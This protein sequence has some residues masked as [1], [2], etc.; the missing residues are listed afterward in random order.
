MPPLLT[1]GIPN[2]NRSAM[3]SD[4]IRRIISL[5]PPDMTQ[6]IE[7]FVSDNN[8]SEDT[9]TVV[10]QILAE[11]RQIQLRFTRNKQNVGFSRNFDKTIKG[12]NGKFVFLMSNDD[13]L[14]DN[15]LE[16]VLNVIKKHPDIGLGFFACQ[17]YDSHLT[18]AVDSFA[19]GLD[20]YYP[21][22]ID[23]V[24]ESGSCAPCLISGWLVN[25]DMW[26]CESREEWMS[27]NAAQI[28]IGMSLLAKHPCY[29][30]R[31]SPVV[32][33]RAE[34][35][36]WDMKRDPLCPYSGLNAYFHGARV[37][38]DWYPRGIYNSI[39]WQTIRTT[40][41][42][43]IRNKVLGI[44]IRTNEV[45]QLL[46]PYFDTSWPKCI[47][48]LILRILLRTPKWMLYF[49]FRLMVSRNSW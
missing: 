34:N 41:G 20:Q 2:Y 24:K 11:N 8:S 15:S 5:M 10:K 35:G 45:E 43:T 38:R 36:I 47:L 48:T 40:C 25:R 44:P 18:R 7:I 37:V 32:K 21:C 39:Y 27:S 31:S 4:L 9:A 28:P 29:H 3:L 14:F 17:T 30:H 33:Y 23:W 6:H 16:I 12:S 42:H 19:P 46:A 26:N 22:G 49:P 13:S 1:I